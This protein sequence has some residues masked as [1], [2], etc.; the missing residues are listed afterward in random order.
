MT[1]DPWMYQQL[2]QASTEAA[3]RERSYS[4]AV[5]PDSRLPRMQPEQWLA[6]HPWRAIL[7]FCAVWG[8]GFLLIALT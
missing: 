4:R 5:G 1:F 2:M 3:T 7:I 8:L 6:V